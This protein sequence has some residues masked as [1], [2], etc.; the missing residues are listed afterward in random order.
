MGTKII[1]GVVNPNATLQFKSAPFTLARTPGGNAKGDYTAT[2]AAG[3]WVV[4]GADR[5]AV[6][7]VTPIGNG[8]FLAGASVSDKGDGSSTMRFIFADASGA[9]ADTLFQFFAIATW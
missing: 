9:P 2:F 1:T 5:I 4:D 7:S 3:T 8:R 6:P